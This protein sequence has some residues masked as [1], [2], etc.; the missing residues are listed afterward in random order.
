MVK[1]KTMMKLFKLKKKKKRKT[2]KVKTMHK[3]D[4][5]ALTPKQDPPNSIRNS[6]RNSFIDEIN[7]TQSEILKPILVET[8]SSISMNDGNNL[9]QSMRFI[10]LFFLSTNA[11]L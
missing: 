4:D 9:L 10:F 6:K 3:N 11:R 8:C 5:Y 2:K 7:Q 1:L